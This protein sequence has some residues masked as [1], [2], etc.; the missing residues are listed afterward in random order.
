MKTYHMITTHIAP[1]MIPNSINMYG[2]RRGHQYMWDTVG[3][4]IQ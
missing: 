3:V 4:V 1:L 2:S